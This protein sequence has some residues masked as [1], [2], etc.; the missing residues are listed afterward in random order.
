[1]RQTILPSS[2]GRYDYEELLSSENLMCRADR[3]QLEQVVMNLV[4]NALD[5]MP[6]KGCLTIKTEK[7]SIDRKNADEYG[8]SSGGNFVC[9]TVQDTGE[10]ID[11]KIK[12][13]IF[14]PFFTTKEVGK[15]IGLGLAIVYRIVKEH[16]GFIK[17]DSVK[18]EGTSFKLY[19]P[20]HSP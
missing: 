9:L 11:A 17:V 5:S 14:E 19:F 4:N 7:V 1:M 20:L 13:K 16:G 6:G 2:G 10:G 15:G 12:S 8:L 3:L 18:R